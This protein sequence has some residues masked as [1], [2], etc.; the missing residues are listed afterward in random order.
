MNYRH[1]Y[2]FYIAFLVIFILSVTSVF[3]SRDFS[4]GFRA[5]RTDAEETIKK[6][7]EIVRGY[8]VPIEGV[9]SSFPILHNSDSSLIV[10][11]QHNNIDV[12]ISS[13]PSASNDNILTESEQSRFDTLSLWSS[14]SMLLFFFLIIA[15]LVLL[16]LLLISLHRSLKQKDIFSSKIYTKMRN[17]GAIMISGSLMASL[18]EYLN[19]KAVA[20]YLLKSDIIPVVRFEPDYTTL[21]FGIALLFISE[22]FKLGYKIQEEQNLT[23]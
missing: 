23:I 15:Q 2:F 10:S 12:K 17:I 22:V 20:I 11:G 13:Y 14:I 21:I 9:E 3:T 4:S 6:S 7:A 5:G 18:S 8:M 16:I 19:N 1:L